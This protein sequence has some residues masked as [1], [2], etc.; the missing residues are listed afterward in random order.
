MF[1]QHLGLDATTERVYQELLA[2][3][4]VDLADIQEATGMDRASVLDALDQLADQALVSWDDHLHRP[5]LIDP[6]TAL[7]ALLAQQESEIAE[8]RLRL[9]AS[10]QAIDQLLVARRSGS[11]ESVDI[12]RVLGLDA[13]LRKIEVL[14]CECRQSVWS[15]NPGG[16][17]SEANLRRSR[18]L[19]ERTLARGVRMRAVYQEAVHNDEATI[20]HVNWL[21]DKGAEVRLAP[22]LP[23][24][25]II[26]DGVKAMVPIDEGNSS[27]GA[28]L[29]SGDGLVTAMT[30]LF[31]AIWRSARPF[32]PRSQRAPGELSAQELHALKLWAQGRTDRAV[33]SALGVSERTIRRMSETIS[34]RLG[35]RSR[36]EAGARAMDAGLLTRED[37]I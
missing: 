24:R 11:A 34:D 26:V 7:H 16:P 10:R 13:V 4:E 15:F 9:S 6:T 29:I 32:G 22:V 21:Q 27:K 18:P 17:Q 5:Q 14:A 2:H 19:N 33:A 3:P 23:L 37:L 30:A 20:E 1:L 25:M 8:Q 12:E 28:L 35:A 31:V 36:F